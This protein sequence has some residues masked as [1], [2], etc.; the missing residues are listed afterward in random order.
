MLENPAQV[1]QALIDLARRLGI[2]VP[3]KR[4]DA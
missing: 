3:E 1:A 4:P 2:A